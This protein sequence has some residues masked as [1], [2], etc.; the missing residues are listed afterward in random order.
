M[1]FFLLGAE[2]LHA[3]RHT[4]RQTDIRTGA[5]NIVVAYR[6]F[7]RTPKNGKHISKPYYI[8]HIIVHVVDCDVLQTAAYGPETKEIAL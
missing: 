6:N 2:L 7:A 5:T 8:C 1:I 3:D 4:D